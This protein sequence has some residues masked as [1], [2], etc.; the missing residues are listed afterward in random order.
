MVPPPGVAQ[1][2]VA[3][4]TDVK[5][6]LVKRWE[7]LAVPVRVL[8]GGPEGC[9]VD[10]WGRPREDDWAAR[11]L[12]WPDGDAGSVQ[13]AA[14]PRQQAEMVVGAV[15]ARG[16]ASSE[17][18]IGAA[19]EE[20]AGELVR[21]FGRRGGELFDPAGTASELGL[22]RWFG[23]W[24][25]WLAEP[26]L[27]AVADLLGR[28][29]TG[30]LVKGK[31]AQKARALC[32]LRDEALADRARDVRKLLEGEMV[33]ERDRE[34][35]G[36]LATALE[37]LEKWRDQFL[38]QGFVR[39]MERLVPILA[40]T[41]ERT[42][43]EA[44]V[45]LEFVE[46]VRE[47]A[48]RLNRDAGFWIEVMLASLPEKRAAAPDG[49]VADVVG[50]L[51]LAFE[52]GRHLVVAGMN[53][54]M[55]PARPSGEP[56][57]SESGRRQLGL[58]TDALR[59]AR[60]AFL[61]A[62][63]CA[64]RRD[65]GRVDVVCGKTSAGGDAL[66]PSRL[67]LAAGRGDLPARV[68][69][70]FREVEPPDA[71]LQWEADWKWEPPARPGPERMHVTG[72]GDYLACPT[73]F[74]LKQV[75][76]M[77]RREVDRNEW[78]ARDFGNVAHEVLER[79]GRDP[80]ARDYSKTKAI[81]EWVEAEME[82]ILEE[83][84]GGE[85]PLAVAIQVESLRQRLWWFARKQACQRAE[86]WEVAEVEKRIAIE[87]GGM[88]VSGKVDRIDR[89]KD[90]RW[91]VLDYKTG[92]VK[93]AEGA[94]RVK[95]TGATR[96]PGHLEG[97]ERLYALSAD[98]KGREVRKVWRNLQLPMYAAG[99]AEMDGTPEVGYFLL[100]ATEAGVGV[101]SWSGFTAADRDSAMQCAELVVEKVQAGVFG[102]PAGRVEY[103]DFAELGMGR[104]LGE[105]VVTA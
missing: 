52:P 15:A 18:A 89:H 19:D 22:A 92:K 24:R 29:E 6:V 77:Q 83:R 55:V 5:P 49:R 3:G 27:A 16:E 102:P 67:L 93:N 96:L 44:G 64:A 43:D 48:G 72:F 32:A 26:R 75:V 8:V 11:E 69:S 70:L 2:V 62:S 13:V 97:D 80:E 101:E 78:N 105:M 91:R 38:A 57:L 88:A 95:V 40:R 104:P 45:I 31:R 71:G 10:E 7:S 66:L 68:T 17:V 99:V 90:G 37:A 14:D 74:Y 51:E 86:G 41:S 1:I 12:P 81:G 60:D 33:R 87:I 47:V 39:S 84:F 61:F 79:W 82:T 34:S 9:G 4:V 59:A 30:V 103:D 21:A 28:S 94:H 20:V 100:G 23:I 53:E 85:R 58:T 36:E 50:W 54:G 25:R 56:W 65:G 46:E 35:V 98:A 63:L 73:R 42:A 76:G